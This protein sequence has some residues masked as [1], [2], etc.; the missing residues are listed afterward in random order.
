M[1]D[2]L[3]VCKGRSWLSTASTDL[4]LTSVSWGWIVV[5]RTQESRMRENKLALVAIKG[6]DS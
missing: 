4:L 1:P 2:G 6:D 5:H 3:C